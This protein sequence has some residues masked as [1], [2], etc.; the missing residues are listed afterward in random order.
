VPDIIV[1]KKDQL[2]KIQAGLLPEE[3]IE[4][5]LDLKNIGSG[6]LGITNK[7]IVFYDPVF[8]RKLK[9]VV[10]IPY[11]RIILVAAQDDA[12]MFTGRGFFA[13]SKLT[14]VTSHGEHEFEF[15]GADKAHLAHNL[16]LGHMV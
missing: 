4:A 3:T 8:L 2:E 10:S 6:F 9:A 16:I 7:R 15:R 12:G 14:L 13:S 1:D 11:S 5:V